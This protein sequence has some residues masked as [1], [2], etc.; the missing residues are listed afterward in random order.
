MW[1]SSMCSSSSNLAIN[2]TPVVVDPEIILLKPLEATRGF[3]AWFVTNLTY[4]AATATA[5]ATCGTCC[6][7]TTAISATV[8]TAIAVVVASTVVSRT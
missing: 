2:V 8:F 1:R 4:R 5:A 6:S 7:I 3:I